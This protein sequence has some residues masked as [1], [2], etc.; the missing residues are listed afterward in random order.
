MCQETNQDTVGRD[1]CVRGKEYDI[2]NNHVVPPQ[3]QVRPRALSAAEV[4]AALGAQRRE[5]I[6]CNEAVC[7]AQG[8]ETESNDFHPRRGLGLQHGDDDESSERK[9]QQQG[10]DGRLAEVRQHR[11]LWCAPGLV[12]PQE[13]L[14]ELIWRG[15]EMCV[16]ES[17]HEWVSVCV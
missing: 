14:S 16:C 13:R 6:L 11:Y 10:L 15:E 9:E 12:A 4:L 8:E 5:P 7:S 2:P 3:E 17:V 1:L